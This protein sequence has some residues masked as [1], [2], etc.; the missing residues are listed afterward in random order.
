MKAAI[1]SAIALA[2][3]SAV[4]YFHDYSTKVEAPPVAVVQP[5][6]YAEAVIPSYVPT[7]KP[8]PHHR[9][10]GVCK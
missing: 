8:R 9:H 1:P 2:V 6:T 5:F 4:A 3:V 10:R 7:P